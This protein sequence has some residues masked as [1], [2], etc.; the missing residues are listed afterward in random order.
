MKLTALCWLQL[1]EWSFFFVKLQRSKPRTQVCSF[2][3]LSESLTSIT[4][5]PIAGQFW[6]LIPQFSA[7][8][9]FQEIG[10]WYLLSGWISVEVEIQQTRGFIGNFGTGKLC[11][12]HLFSHQLT[13]NMTKDCS[14]IYQ[15]STWKLQAQNMLCTQIVFYFCFDIQSNMFWPCSFH[16]L[17]NLLSYYGL[18]DVRINASDQDL[19]VHLSIYAM[20]VILWKRINKKLR[21]IYKKEF[22]PVIRW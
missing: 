18:V 3:L 8:F 11:Q 21:M 7:L 22:F 20:N 6:A 13:H 19:P 9:D 12:K 15:F 16:V 2:S 10:T 5:T 17:N 1:S 4:T 14:L